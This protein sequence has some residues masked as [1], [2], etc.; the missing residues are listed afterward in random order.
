MCANMWHVGPSL[1][2]KVWV[3]LTRSRRPTVSSLVHTLEFFEARG[4]CTHARAEYLVRK[5]L[6]PKAVGEARAATGRTAPPSA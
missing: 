5:V 4:D 1:G 2:K 3:A 6:K